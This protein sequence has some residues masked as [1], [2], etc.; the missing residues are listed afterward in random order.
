MWY[1]QVRTG[2]SIG[3]QSQTQSKGWILLVFSRESAQNASSLNF[4]LIL[5]AKHQLT[6]ITPGQKLSFA[7][8]GFIGYHKKWHLPLGPPHNAYDM[9]LMEDIIPG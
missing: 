7:L 6:D 2:S 9:P 1:S 3:L 4:N 8:H 5:E